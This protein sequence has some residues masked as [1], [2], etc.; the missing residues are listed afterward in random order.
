[1]ADR[2]GGS[3]YPTAYYTRD[4]TLRF[5]CAPGRIFHFT[6]DLLIVKDIEVIDKNR[7]ILRA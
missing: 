3:H 2:P 6:I 1:M 5:I 7:F 4:K